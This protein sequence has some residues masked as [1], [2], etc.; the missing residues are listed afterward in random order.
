MHMVSFIL[1]FLSLHIRLD[2]VKEKKS[3]LLVKAQQGSLYSG[4]LT[5]GQNLQQCDFAGGRL[6]STLNKHSGS[7]VSI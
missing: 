3:V 2:V 4:P 5:Q 7:G 6:G 1:P